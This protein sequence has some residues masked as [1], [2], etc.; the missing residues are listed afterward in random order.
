MIE[1][2]AGQR[3]IALIIAWALISAS[4]ALFA[5][6]V[7]SQSRVIQVPAGADLQAAI[8][9]ASTGDTLQL[10]NAVYSGNFVEN[11]GLTII[12]P[13]TIKTPNTGQALY[14]P[15]RTPKGTL[16]NLTVTITV[17][18]VNDIIRH[19]S[20]GAE[21][22]SL[23]EVPQGLMLENVDVTG[24]PG[25]ETKRGVTANGANLIVRNSKIREIHVKGNGDTQAI[26]GWNGPG[27][28]LVEDSY[29]E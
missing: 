2:R 5:P 24:L 29:L 17:T 3:A 7:T 28:V 23:D 13:A 21:Q 15:P 14:Y 9:S 19:G 25:L 8:N 16:R 20:Q 26:C 4:I 12:G 1:V 18:G 6:R 27:P 10:A 22:D 11:K